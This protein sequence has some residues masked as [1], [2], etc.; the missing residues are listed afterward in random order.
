MNILHIKLHIKKITA[1]MLSALLLISMTGCDD[2]RQRGGQFS[3]Q[4]AT[5]PELFAPVVMN[6]AIQWKDETVKKLIYDG[7]Q[8][9]YNDDVY[10]Y[11]LSNITSLY[12]IADKKIMLDGRPP[13][14]VIPEKAG[15]I[16]FSGVVKIEGKFQR[17]DTVYTETVSLCLDDLIYF[18]ALDSL[19]IYLVEPVSLEF[20][21]H[22]PQLKYLAMGSCN[23]TDISAIA[24]CESL[25][26][27]WLP[28]NNISDLSPLTG[29]ELWNLDMRG[30]RLEDISP[31]A[32]MAQ[33]PGN[34][35]LSYNSI[36]DIS[37]LAPMGRGTVLP[38]LNLRD[39]NISDISPLAEYSQIGILSLTNNNITDVNPLTNL[40]RS[41]MLYL[42]G[43][44]V[45]NLSV[46]SGFYTVYTA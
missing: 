13:E 16:P 32:D 12:I 20:V 45:E 3:G 10:P 29:L 42:G 14:N 39:N 40:D 15:E 6:E 7:L 44:P 2:S 43:N 9:D 23:L 37:A 17:V 11:E 4:P 35:V 26:T 5:E 28:Y 33:L 41:N 1:L 34:L 8:R 19:Y 46:L 25:H 36:S 30:N 24:G 31:L 21:S 18:T 27:L 22:L 38:Y